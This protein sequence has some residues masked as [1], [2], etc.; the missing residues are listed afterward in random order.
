MTNACNLGARNGIKYDKPANGRQLMKRQLAVAIL[1]FAAA[2]GAHGDDISKV[3]SSIRVAA[4]EQV[5]DVSTVNGSIRIHERASAQDVGTVNG[6]IDIG[7]QAVA[8]RVH[9]V[10]GSIRL[11][12]GANAGAVETVNGTLK[13]GPDA[14]IKDRVKAVN[15]YIKLERGAEVGGDVSNVN[16]NISIE[17][18]HVGGKLKTT[19]GDVLIAA[20]SRI[21]GG[22]LVEEPSFQWFNRK[23]RTPRIV[24]GP[25]AVVAGTIDIEHDVDLYVS[26]RA[27]TGRIEGAKPIVF[28]GDE[29]DDDQPRERQVER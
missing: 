12:D 14:R 6:S 25:N 2:L 11:D 16:G 22:I 19:M 23:W 29:P 20:N 8:E 15:G 27:K 3:N 24:I 26:D 9:T 4:G 7:K 28:S 5:E 13:V 21:D 1:T 18:A 17:A 10:N